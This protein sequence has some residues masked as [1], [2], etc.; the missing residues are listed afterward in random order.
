MVQQLIM[1]GSDERLVTLY[2][3]PMGPAATAPLLI[4]LHANGESPAAMVR[5]SGIDLLAAREGV[6][7]ALPPARDRRWQA[8]QQLGEAPAPSSDVAYVSGLIDQLLADQPVDPSRVYVAGFSMGAALTDRIACQLADRVAAVAI[9]AG[10]PWGGACEPSA[11]V[12]VLVMHGTA[13]ATFSIERASQMVDRWRT[14]AGCPSDGAPPPEVIG[15]ATIATYACEAGADVTFV[16]VEGGA[17]RWFTQPDA[18]A[19]A[20]EFLGAHARH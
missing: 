11:P 6:I 5:E 12:S 14:L 2:L 4:L 19:L 13:D 9:D 8:L 3:P 1:V 10:T 15:P 17:H 16:T 7:V 18:T 20:W